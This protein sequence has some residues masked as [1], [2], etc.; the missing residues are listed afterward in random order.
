M[1]GSEG[2]EPSRDLPTAVRVDVLHETERTRVTRIM[3]AAGSLIR[4]EPLG[5][6][7]DWRLLHETEILKRLSGVDGVAQLADGSPSC[8]GSILLADVG[9]IALCE[10][11][12][13]LAPVTLVELAESLARAVAEMHRRGVAH[14][15][16]NPANIVV[17]GNRNIPYLVDFA[18]AASIAD[19]RPGFLHHREIVGTVPY[20]APEQTGRTARLVDQRA[21][22]YALGATL[23]ELATGAPPFGSSDPARIIQDHLVRIP[24]PP[25]AV[26]PLLPAELS[27]IIMHLLKK[28]PDDRYQTADGLVRDLVLLRRGARI[29]DPGAHDSPLRPLAPSRL[30]GRDEEIRDLG[31]AFAEAM[32]G[33]CRG[34]LVSG[35][36]GVGKTSLVNELRP[37]VAGR[38]GW[39]VTGKFDQFRRD[40]EYDGVRQAF[41]ALGRLLLAE[42]EGRLAKVREQLLDALGPNAELV[43]AA[44]PELAALLKVAPDPGDPMTARVRLQHASVAVLRTITSWRRPLV[45][46]VDDLQWAGRTPLGF[47]DLILG[48]EEQTEGLL[49]VGAYRDS[50]VDIAHPLAPMLDRWSRQ[51][52]GPHHQRLGN[53]VPAGQ[54][55]LVADI[56]HIAPQSASE[57]A[58]MIES[59]TEGS[60]YDTVELFNALRHEGLIAPGESRWHVD[61]SA[62][63][64]RLA[65]LDIKKLLAARVASLPSGTREVLMAMA[66]LAGRVELDLLATATGLAAQEVERRLAPAYAAA[67]LVRELDDRSTIRF[68]HDRTQK[69]L[70]DRITATEQRAVRLRLA[71]CLSERDE[72]FAVAAEQYLLVADAVHATQERQLM[73]ALFRRAAGQARI[74]SNYPLEERFLTAA[75]PLIDPA[76]TDQLIA[77]GTER[78]AALH[79]LGLLEEADEA[80]ETVCRLCTH[81]TQRTAAVEAQVV[82][83]TNRGL[84]REAMRL[85]LDQLRHLGFAVPDRD[86][87]DSDIDRGLKEVRQWIDRTDESDDLRLAGGID[88]SRLDACRIIDR[89]LPAAY[90]CDQPMLGW[91]TVKV[92]EMWVQNGPHATFLG[93]AAGAAWTIGSRGDYRTGYRVVQR[94]LSVSRSLGYDLEIGRAQYLYAAGVG[95]W[96]DSLEENISGA[97]RALEVLV[98]SGDL[99][100]ASYTRYMLV[101]NLLD[102]APTLDALAPEVDAA[103]AAG[104]GTGNAHLVEN[105][106]PCRQLIRILR[107]ETVESEADEVS[108]LSRLAANPIARA[109]LHIALALA[110]AIFDH[111]ARL[112]RHTAASMRLLPVIEPMYV[113]TTARLLRAMSLAA[114]ARATEASQ[115]E[116]SLA[117]LDELV[118]WLSARAADAPV[119][120]L[121]LLRLVEA[122]QAW[123]VGDFHKAAYMF[124]VAQREASTRDRPWHRALILERTARFYL[125]HGMLEA[126]NA[127]LAAARRQYLAWGAT[128]KVSQLDWV[129]PVQGIEFTAMEPDA[130]RLAEPAGCKPAATTRTIDLFGI[131]AASQALGSETT[132]DGLRARVAGIL[133]EMTGATSVHLLLHEQNEVGWS[134]PVGDG[135][136]ISL[137]EAGRRRMLPASVI[138]Y[139]DRTHQPL[140]IDDA[141]HD[142]RFRRDLYFADL[143]RCSLLALPI[144]IRGTQG[145]MLLLE[146]RMIRSAFTIERLEGIML[147]A[148]QLAVSLD[149]A[150]VYAS[151]ERKV[152][153]R[154]QQLSVVNRRLLQL[155]TTDPLTGLANRR[156]LSEVLDVEWNRAGRNSTPIALTIVDIDYFKLYNDHFG[157]S[158]GD[159]CLKKVA[160]CLA[161]NIRDTHL[162]ARY[163]GEEFAVVMP[164]TGLGAAARLA[165]RSR[166]AVEELAEPHPLVERGVVTV[167]IG[168]AAAV[169]PV[170]GDLNA[171][172]EVADAALY[173]AK[174]RGRNRVAVARR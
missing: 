108:A 97:R 91:L 115:R 98:R 147:V 16:I 13:P 76:D 18:L 130:R 64:R 140:A 12:M 32:A 37:M 113:T 41:R 116:A 35:A 25:A 29:S 40:E 15:N 101:H 22:L 69:S 7:A 118:A 148:G 127:P 43:A 63:R 99:Q 125:S 155:S 139:V 50:D 121:H 59:I 135:D 102:C 8:P 136:T 166:S 92:L 171:F 104:A 96:F 82:S 134:V 38:N 167:S 111:P 153:E 173:K 159:Q 165:H 106:Q 78:H 70:L 149:N 46:V 81:P 62:L 6:G 126:G 119:N 45:F 17:G 74:L 53:L 89:L 160:A 142:E 67:L 9:G 88:H 123:A 109:H 169:P 60:P 27:A 28:E 103:L 66:C 39:F 105:V 42:P 5:P 68:H 120:F 107:G 49:L 19:L 20:L 54:A 47:I 100:N 85:G 146:N 156:R 86:H 33:H 129:H 161:K 71:R 90:F 58:R 93:P 128:A 124:D 56:L 4:K 138:W 52:T 110:A 51:P 34:L 157:H 143:D 72:Y 132:I 131:A 122:E 44:L 21:D 95:H 24:V 75:M 162:V 2:T 112:A 77:V 164:R 30:A 1:D 84:A 31:A 87:L 36:A 150:Q 61:Q 137:D 73:A 172:F 3:S 151:L 133:S 158:A 79:R 141:T 114:Q 144:T 48:S 10:L 154:T 174:H 55:S 117:E 80:Y 145:A 163:G 168:V 83:L 23:Y 26:N 65:G 14:Q 94:L 170:D 152:A 11:A 57:L